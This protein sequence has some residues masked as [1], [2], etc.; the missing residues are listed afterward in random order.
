MLSKSGGRRL[1]KFSLIWTLI[2]AIFTAAYSTGL[3]LLYKDGMNLIKAETF[4]WCNSFYHYYYQRK[5]MLL[6]GFDFDVNKGNYL[7]FGKIEDDG[8]LTDVY[9]TD[10]DS[11]ELN[12]SDV[13]FQSS[14]LHNNIIVRYYLTSDANNQGKVVTSTHET[15]NKETELQSFEQHYL[16]CPEEVMNMIRTSQKKGTLL[17][18]QLI[19]RDELENY[20]LSD[21]PENGL[22]NKMIRSLG[23]FTVFISD[24]LIHIFDDF[25]VD[26]YE[27]VED[28]S[29][30]AYINR[31]DVDPEAGKII[32]GELSING[33]KY[34]F[35]DNNLTDSNTTIE[36]DLHKRPDS[37]LEKNKDL[38]RDRFDPDYLESLQYQTKTDIINLYSDNSLDKT[39]LE[40]FTYDFKKEDGQAVLSGICK[41]EDGYF[42]YVYIFPLAGFWETFTP[43]IAE[44]VILVWLPGLIIAGAVS[45]IRSRKRYG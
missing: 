4:I 35:P 24:H 43:W 42:R 39:G 36:I 28:K 13:M 40:R 45:M 23:K 5:D 34:R 14:D 19:P 32:S 7:Y 12:N 16:L 10:Y 38:L 26:G 27:N 33:K 22:L 37:I 11:F 25:N 8:S 31:A 21:Y 44:P 2:A 29:E 1:L 20:C 30:G 15:F 17:P 18:K 6:L 41:Y 9:K 3:Y